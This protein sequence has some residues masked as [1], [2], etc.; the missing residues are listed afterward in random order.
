MTVATLKKLL[1]ASLL[2]LVCLVTGAEEPGQTVRVKLKT[3]LGTIVLELDRA[4]APLTVDNFLKY[5]N[6]YYYDGLIFHRVVKG[7]MIQSGGYTY[8][9]VAKEPDEPVS[10]E[11]G[12]GLRNLRGT[13]AMART[14]DPDSAK[15]QFFIN[16]ADN[17]GLDASGD[18]AGYSVFGRVVDGMDVADTIANVRVQGFDRFKHMPVDP[19][20]ILSV[21]EI[22]AQ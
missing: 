1:T 10:N 5:V 21:R 20:Q 7:F 11:S 2:V 17:P 13:I 12:N 4:R 19:V 18:R 22:P 14:A 9:L 15:A 8:D 16:V 6:R 3:T